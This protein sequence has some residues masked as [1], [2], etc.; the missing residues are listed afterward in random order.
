MQAINSLGHFFA[1]R[2]GEAAAWAEKAVRERPNMLITLPGDSYASPG[3][4]EDT[5]KTI[6]RRSRCG[7]QPSNA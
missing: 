5:H 4:Y 2:H 3:R 1:G 6:A 7:R